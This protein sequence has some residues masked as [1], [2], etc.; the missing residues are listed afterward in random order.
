MLEQILVNTWMF[1]VYRIRVP[2]VT[3]KKCKT[4]SEAILRK[5]R[6]EQA[7]K[8]PSFLI[9]ESRAGPHEVNK[10]LSYTSSRSQWPRW[11]RGLRHEMSSLARTLGSWV[12]IPLKAWMFVYVYSV[13]VVLCR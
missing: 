8:W 7:K 1:H 3:N 4:F 11:P 10:E 13:C 5:L 12:L 2:R 6:S 9:V